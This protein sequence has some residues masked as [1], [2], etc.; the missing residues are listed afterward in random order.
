MPLAVY[1][2]TNLKKKKNY[3]FC[4]PTELAAAA[5]IHYAVTRIWM[6][7]VFI[8]EIKWSFNIW[9]ERNLDLSCMALSAANH[10]RK[11]YKLHSS[12]V[13]PGKKDMDWHL[14]VSPNE[15]GD[16]SYIFLCTCSNSYICLCCFF[17]GELRHSCCCLWY[18]RI[19]KE[20]EKHILFFV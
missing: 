3:A 10:L 17:G 8:V 1:N 16:D 18:W 7:V 13:S 6:M 9:K 20:Q 5:R 15:G 11:Y 14:F 19:N 2:I 12:S 4:C